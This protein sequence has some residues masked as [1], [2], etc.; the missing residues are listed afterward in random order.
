M[1]NKKLKD[2]LNNLAIILGVTA[3]A[4]LIFG[5]IRIFV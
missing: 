1:K 5:I 2:I 3:I 4:V